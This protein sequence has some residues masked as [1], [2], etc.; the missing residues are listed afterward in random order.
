ML[1]CRKTL[2]TTYLGSPKDIEGCR[3]KEA[4][5][6]ELWSLRAEG[7]TEEGSF[8]EYPKINALTKINES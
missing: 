1:C 5:D 6:R 7:V 4:S 3:N 2:N 8:G